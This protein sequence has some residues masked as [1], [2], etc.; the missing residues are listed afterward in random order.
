MYIESTT[1]ALAEHAQNLAQY[2]WKIPRLLAQLS[3]LLGVFLSAV[4][5]VPSPASSRSSRHASIAP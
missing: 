4:N 1:R 5:K 3:W 2:S